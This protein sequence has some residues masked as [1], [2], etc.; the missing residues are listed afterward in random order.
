MSVL[1]MLLNVHRS[2][3][4]FGGVGSTGV[5]LE[6][7]LVVIILEWCLEPQRAWSLVGSL[8]FP[9]GGNLF[10]VAHSQ[11]TSDPSPL[12]TLRSTGSS[13]CPPE[14]LRQ[15]GWSMG[16]AEGAWS[17][18]HPSLSCQAECHILIYCI[19]PAGIYCP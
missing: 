7:C 10:C 13:V 3:L 6:T 18:W 5:I 1:R 12:F 16:K 15:K 8:P 17:F 4:Q 11:G 2:T 19:M 9:S 14:A